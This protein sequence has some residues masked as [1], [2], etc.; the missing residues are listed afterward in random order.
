MTINILVNALPLTGLLTGIA[1][2]VRNLYFCLE[3]EQAARIGYFIGRE[4]A[5]VMP[6]QN[7]TATRLLKRE[8]LGRL[9]SPLLCSLRVANWFW[10]E[11]CLRRDILTDGGYNI[12][13]ETG[14]FPPDLR[15]RLPVV[16]TVYDLSLRR[17]AHTH[18][19]VR[20]CYYEFFIKRRLSHAT[21]VL[22]ISEYVRQE[23]LDE[24]R[25][26]PQM[27]TTVPLAP[28]PHFSPQAKEQVDITLARLGVPRDY[29]L[30]AGTLEPRK[31]L[32]LLIE[33]LPLMRQEVA[34]VLAG[35]S[36]WG[37]KSWRKALPA[38]GLD[39][40]VFISGHVSDEDLACLYTGAS[41]FVYPSLYEG[42]GL[43]IL[44]SMACGCPVV[45]ANTSCLPETAG[46][47]AVLVSPHDPEELAAALD[48]IV[49]D[50]V[51]RQGLIKLSLER[52]AGF[53]WEQ[54]ARQTMAVF[55]S[56][57]AS[58]AICESQLKDAAVMEPPSCP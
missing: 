6:V 41:A 12:Y 49:E 48:H 4:T 28:D 34:L 15:G 43:P 13:H 30:F 42:F 18:P 3:K 14:F 25:L 37:D 19:R 32:K 44:E 24:F 20:V 5:P 46:G 47:A 2:Y 29:I 36:G 45:C 33:A 16:H 40:R 23:I 50:D 38:L 1:R 54:T 51:Y 27:V 26:D 58:E 55:K 21:H 17:Y 7:S 8:Q 9:P 52:A 11:H 35:A 10:H 57:S 22:A 39:R 53:S 56:V 31:N